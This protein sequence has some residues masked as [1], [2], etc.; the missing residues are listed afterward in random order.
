MPKIPGQL[1]SI[2]KHPKELD[3]VYRQVATVIN[4]GLSFGDGNHGQSD[5]INGTWVSVQTPGTS[6]TDF[7]VQ[8]NLNRV[9]SGVIVMQKKGAACDVFI[10]PDDPGTS[11]SQVILRASAALVNVVLFIV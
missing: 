11:T 8:H 3:N 6:N 4:G 2:D 1:Q 10:S 9:A 7:V 5:N